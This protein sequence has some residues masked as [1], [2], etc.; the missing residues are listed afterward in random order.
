MSEAE[1]ARLKR[2]GRAASIVLL[3]LLLIFFY[4]VGRFVV[5]RLDRSAVDLVE[6]AVYFVL[7]LV[8]GMGAALGLVAFISRREA[9]ARERR[10]IQ[11]G[12][13]PGF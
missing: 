7:T 6:L 11:A 4:L 5:P 2:I 8:V 10:E 1:A 12:H 9:V 13:T 3:E